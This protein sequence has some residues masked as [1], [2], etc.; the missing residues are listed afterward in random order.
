MSLR[1]GQTIG[2]LLMASAAGS[3][4]LTGAYL[5]AA[6]LALVAFVLVFALVR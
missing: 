6:G 3:L 1:A 5:A 4:G 2:P